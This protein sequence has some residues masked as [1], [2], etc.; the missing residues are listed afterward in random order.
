MRPPRAT[1]AALVA[2]ASCLFAA[3]ADA[4]VLERVRET[5]Q[6]RLGYRVDAMPFSYPDAAGLP[7][8]Y[9]VALCTVVAER[10][11]QE[12]GLAR[13][14]VAWRQV[15]AEDRFE[16][17]RR[18]EVDLLCSADTVTLGRRD[19]VDFS[20]LTFAT[21]ATLLY[22]ADGPKT[23]GELK[24]SKVAVLEATTTEQEL[25]DA[26]A[27]QRIEGVE[28]L[29]V[30]SHAE[31]IRRLAAG[32]LGAY[33]GDGAIL[34]YQWLDSPER[35][36]LKLSSHAFSLE[37]YALVVPKGDDAFRLL[38]DRTLAA[39]YRSREIDRIFATSFKGAEP[40]D[41]VKALYRLNALDE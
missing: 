32:E 30:A 23:F 31:G 21:G 14:D 9:S 28:L 19:A 41:F 1:P 17:V 16:R 6:L 24:G 3:S 5:G 33:F 37:P 40:S 15:T 34:L 35:D 29:T 39:L 13:L 22:R 20:L 2:I 25:R 27:E 12:L 36:R 8:G 11:R 7:A 38:V 10:L 4:G 26:L 18:G